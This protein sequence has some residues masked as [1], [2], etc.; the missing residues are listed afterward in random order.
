MSVKCK[1]DKESAEQ[2]TKLLRN[3]IGS[4]Q[5]EEHPSIYVTASVSLAKPGA[6][7]ND[8]RMCVDTFGTQ[9]GGSFN[10]FR[11]YARSADTGGSMTMRQAHPMGTNG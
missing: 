4:S 5:Q 3:S 6:S 2:W 8:S 11:R 9:P 7:G 1:I 10:H